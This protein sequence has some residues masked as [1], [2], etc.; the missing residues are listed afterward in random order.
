[1]MIHFT[2]RIGARKFS[3][4]SVPEVELREACEGILAAT[5]QLRLT[6][7]WF[8]GDSGTIINW[9]MKYLNNFSIDLKHLLLPDIIHFAS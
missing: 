7:I 8:K 1:M 3:A 4:S 5:N 9:M 6:R 2:C